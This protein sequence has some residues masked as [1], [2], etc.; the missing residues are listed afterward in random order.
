MPAPEPVASLRSRSGVRLGVD[1]SGAVHSAWGAATPVQQQQWA[2]S[3]AAAASADQSDARARSAAVQRL[4]QLRLDSHAHVRPRVQAFGSHS[5]RGL[6]SPPRAP[7]RT[8]SP[9]AVS[10]P[11]RDGRELGP[12]SPS[13]SRGADVGVGVGVGV[14]VAAARDLVETLQRRVERALAHGHSDA[15]HSDEADSRSHSLRP[16][17]LRLQRSVGPHADGEPTGPS[18]E[19][20]AEHA[21][22]HVQQQYELHQRRL[23]EQQWQRQQ[24]QRA[25]SVPHEWRPE[26]AESTRGSQL[27]LLVQQLERGLR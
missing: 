14:G 7:S 22:L 2:D 11:G 24:Q 27:L 5:P 9:A 10:P 19:A 13:G 21:P 25:L 6:E 3:V 12:L 23:R 8:L 4:H 20:H 1:P 18:F 26:T 16:T 17:A 15:D